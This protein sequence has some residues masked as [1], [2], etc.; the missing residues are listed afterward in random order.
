MIG[1]YTALNKKEVN[2]FKKMFSPSGELGRL[3]YLFYGIV[4]PVLLIV[5]GIAVGVALH[6]SVPE[7]GTAIY[8]F[9]IFLSL[10]VAF[11]TAVKRANQTGSSVFLIMFLWIF[12][13]PV[14]VIYLLFAPAKPKSEGESE[15]KGVHPVV[16]I[17]AIF[18]MIILLGIVSAVVLP[19][20]AGVKEEANQTQPV[21]Q[22]I[23]TP[24]SSLPSNDG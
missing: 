9:M 4:A 13:T 18:G 1:Y 14:A 24:Q 16:I 22:S 10:Y 6:E 5:I 11:V 21:H 12:L 20:L 19:K 2:V 15:K 3:E 8:I 17:V 23:T 7:I